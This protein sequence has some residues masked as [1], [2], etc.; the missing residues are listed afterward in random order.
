MLWLP[1][2]LAAQSWGA[3]TLQGV[4]QGVIAAL[5][6]GGFYSYAVQKVGASEASMM[7]ALVPAVTAVGAYLILGEALGL[8]TI[9]GIVVVSIGALL[10]A[11]AGRTRPPARARLTLRRR[12]AGSSTVQGSRTKHDEPAGTARAIAL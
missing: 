5:V 1:D 2:N 3:I 7:L 6:A 8:T 9:V 4:Y 11:A 12:S 10:G